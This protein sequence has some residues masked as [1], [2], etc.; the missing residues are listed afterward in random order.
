M[1]TEEI[2]AIVLAF[3]GFLFFI[4]GLES[5]GTG[6]LGVSFGLFAMA[7]TVLSGAGLCLT[8]LIGLVVTIIFAWILE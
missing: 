8:L 1:T 4:G 5:R 7:I 2:V 3:M 6:T